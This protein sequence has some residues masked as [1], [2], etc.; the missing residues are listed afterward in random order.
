MQSGRCDGLSRRLPRLAA[1]LIINISELGSAG[2]DSTGGERAVSDP[3]AKQPGNGAGG[4]ARC[5]RPAG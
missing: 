3:R 1:A 5:Q 2:S 4:R